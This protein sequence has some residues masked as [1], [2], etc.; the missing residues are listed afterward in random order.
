MLQLRLTQHAAGEGRHRVE[1]ALEGDGAR[2]T[3]ESIFPFLLSSQD[4]EDLRWYL[5]DYLQYPQEPAPAIAR[6]I[7][8]RL[9]DLGTELFRAVFQASDDARDL[10]AG[11]RNRLPDTRV[12]IV[13]GVAEAS[14][15]PWELLRDPKTDSPL[16]LSARSF[17][18]AHPSA[19]LHPYLPKEEPDKIRILLVI[20]RPQGD[21]DVP[22]R[23]VASR[24][25]KGLDE[26]NREAYDLDVLRPPTFEQ[27]GRVLRRARQESRPY[28]IVHFDGHGTYQ[29]SAEPGALADVLRGLSS[30]VLAGPR[31]GRHGFLLF[32]NSK[33]EENA[34]LVDG[35]SLGKLLAEAQVPVLVLNACRSAHAEPAAEPG[36]AADPHSQVRAFGSF[37]QEVMDAG[38]AGVVAMRYNVYVVTAAQLAAELY[39]SLGRGSALGE[40]VTLARKNLHDNPLREVTFD[41]IP[42]QD[43]PVPVVFEAAPVQLF[44]KANERAGLQIRIAAG[45]TSSASKSLDSSLP[46]PPDAGFFGR[47]ETLLALDRAFD[48][49]SIVLL[50]AYAG[51]GKTATSAE[52]ARWYS[53]TGGVEGPVLFTSFEHYLPLPRVLDRIGQFFGTMLER[54]GIHW[55][56]LT[57]AQRRDTALQVLDQ[58][59]VLWIWDNVEPVAGFPAGTESIWSGEE[60]AELVAFLRDARSTKAKFLLT[61]RRDERAWLGDL[62]TRITVPAMP[63]TE[64]LQLARALATKHGRRL[65]DVEDWR[66]LLAFTRGNPMT[67]TVLVGQ[68]LRQGFTT[69]EQIES[70][71]AQLRSGEAAFPDEVSEGRSRSLGASL[72]Y[73][74][75]HAFT[76]EERKKLALLHLFQG[77]VD[78]DALCLMGN[79]EIPGY[80]PEIQGLTREEGITLLDRA[81]E[82]GLLT[83]HGNGYYSIHPALPWFFKNAFVKV[84]ADGGSTA[85]R[86]FVYAMSY[87]G[88][89]YHRQYQEGDGHVVVGLRFEEENFL[90][91]YRLAKSHD[92][93]TVVLGSLQ[94]LQQLYQHTGR[95]AEWKRLVE[96]VVPD[97]INPESD[98][99]LPG[100]EED[101]NIVT[102]YR[103]AISRE[104]RQWV[105]AERLQLLHLDWA[106]QNAVHAL[107]QPTEELKGE[108]WNA[109]RT[110]AASL[111]EWGQIRRELGQVECIAAY[112][113]SLELVERIGDR[114]GAA[115]CALNLG[116]AFKNL[117]EVGDLDQAEYWYQKSLELTDE[118]DRMGRYRCRAQLGAI[119]RERF[120]V[121]QA[122][123]QPASIFFGYLYRAIKRY[124]EASDLLPSDAVDELAIV[125]NQL[126]LLYRLAKDSSRA[127]SNFRQSIHLWEQ[128]GD[129]FRAAQTRFNM[130]IVFLEEG[131]QSDALEYAEA[132]LRGYQSFGERAAENIEEARR[133]IAKIHN[134]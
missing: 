57:D 34:E 91:A 106:R 81:A 18:R 75:E 55:L 58:I 73:G 104:A 71:V 98:K 110:L 132:A 62:P 69:R 53:L 96:E 131:R 101:W 115:T 126:G 134:K 125:Y 124:R 111:H 95:R 32:E 88:D 38:V 94:A 35:T 72:A 50:H 43:W 44:P 89:Y 68:A 37:A 86:A 92:W 65:S 7:E 105:K 90:L 20:C 8:G 45:D 114:A 119:A 52:L 5:E 48:Q 9:V 24:L 31:T 77:F 79:P 76:E 102:G 14:A 130:A 66:P 6:R 80:L 42:L 116:N 84:Y 27:L 82:V 54:A 60:Q 87:L 26:A 100:F 25:I 13:T 15:I 117:P 46:P 40:A 19:A 67:L 49:D 16:A 128:S 2:R 123:G 56:T 99:A 4:E 103:V 22:F 121:A 78:V 39:A 122:A 70:F 36:I 112:K 63:M 33:L 133:F 93:L 17:V 74:F 10:W 97:F 109:I 61:S 29:E 107:A 108:E 11:M 21:D 1:I 51:S 64:R 30:L 83:T 120:L 118:R 28:H 59:P 129:I 47:D 127:L 12:E 3:A 113:E 41:P 23:S 85:V